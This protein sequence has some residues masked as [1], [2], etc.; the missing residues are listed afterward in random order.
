MNKDTLY[1]IKNTS[2][3]LPI[4]YMDRY[5]LLKLKNAF[6]DINNNV[7]TNLTNTTI[8]YHFDIIRD[9]ETEEKLKKLKTIR[10]NGFKDIINDNN[11]YTKIPLINELTH[12]DNAIIRK[13]SF[14]FSYEYLGNANEWWKFKVESGYKPN[15]FIKFI[16]KAHEKL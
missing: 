16:D 1:Y 2:N 7:S 15:Y 13:V 10:I 6:P 9:Y 11:Y 4:F 8:F 14:N 12:V 5:L 3:K